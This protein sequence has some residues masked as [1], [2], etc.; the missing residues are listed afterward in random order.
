M[1]SQKYPRRWKH[2]CWDGSALSL[3]VWLAASCGTSAR[4]FSNGPPQTADRATSA[5]HTTMSITSQVVTASLRNETGSVSDVY[6]YWVLEFWAEGQWGPVGYLGYTGGAGN[7]RLCPSLEECGAAPVEKLLAPGEQDV[8]TVIA[9]ALASG[10][11]RVR[12][13]EAGS[14]DQV[15]D[16]FELSPNRG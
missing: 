12:A 2:R 11:Y 16:V 15:A 7:V 1:T 13:T 9:T 10:F 14:T 3:A 4:P 6:P 5:L 8:R